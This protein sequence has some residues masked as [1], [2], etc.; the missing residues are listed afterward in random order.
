MKSFKIYNLDLSWRKPL[1]SNRRTL[2]FLIITVFCLEKF[3]ILLYIGSM[4]ALFWFI[5]LNYFKTEPTI[6]IKLI[7]FSKNKI[8]NKLIFENN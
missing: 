4:E 7:E 2:E 5:K 8:F 3:S 6:V 1:E